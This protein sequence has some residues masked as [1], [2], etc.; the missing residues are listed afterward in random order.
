MALV[1]NIIQWV[2]MESVVSLL[3]KDSTVMLFAIHFTIKA[4]YFMVF[5][6]N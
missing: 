1:I 5:K 6:E 2:R 4:Y 3:L